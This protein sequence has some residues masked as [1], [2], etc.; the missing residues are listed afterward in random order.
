V[1]GGIGL[2]RPVEAIAGLVEQPLLFQGPE[3][4]RDVAAERLARDERQLE[5]AALQVV[6]EDERVLRIDQAPARAERQRDSP[7]GSRGTDPSANWS[8][9]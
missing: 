3:V 1:V 8:P 7:D 2:G 4:R 5:R 6:H 9:P